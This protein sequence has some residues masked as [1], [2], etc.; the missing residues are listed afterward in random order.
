MNRA[1]VIAKVERE[2]LPHLAE[3]GFEVL[4]DTGKCPTYRCRQEADNGNAYFTLAWMSTWFIVSEW[5]SRSPDGGP[6]FVGEIGSLQDLR[7]ILRQIGCKVQQRGHEHG[8]HGLGPLPTSVGA[9]AIRGQVVR[10][11]FVRDQLCRLRTGLGMETGIPEGER[12][13][14]EKLEE[15]VDVAVALRRA[16]DLGGWDM[17][18]C[19]GCGELVVC[20]PDGMP[21]CEPCAE[22]DSVRDVE[23]SLQ[24]S[25]TCEGS[26]GS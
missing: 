16:I 11:Q 26:R 1:D 19:R 12:G 4:D 22:K 2:I 23:P 20:L 5:S 9:P 14:E 6:R 13:I 24:S 15:A 25:D 18:P 8:N 10:K 7:R 21:Y 3:L 17:S